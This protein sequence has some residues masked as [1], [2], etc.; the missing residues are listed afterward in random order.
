MRCSVSLIEYAA[1]QYIPQ[2]KNSNDPMDV[3][4][5]DGPLGAYPQRWRR[6]LASLQVQIPD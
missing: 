4:A 6:E 2:L 3:D 1:V 5:S